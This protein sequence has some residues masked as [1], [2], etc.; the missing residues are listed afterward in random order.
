MADLVNTGGIIN[1][2]FL[3]IVQ[4]YSNFYIVI[5]CLIVLLDEI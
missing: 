4:H 2:E 5:L 1:L 3:I